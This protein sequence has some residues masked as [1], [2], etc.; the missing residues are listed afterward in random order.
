[1]I[2]NPVI[3]HHY[4]AIE[5]NIGAGKTTLCEMISK[6]YGCKLI[7]EQ[8]TDN[9]FLAS[10]YEQPE[11]YA[12]PVELFFMTERHK[13]M[14]EVFRDTD[15]F[16][17]FYLSDYF[18]LKTLLF[19]GKNL[20][21][22]EFRLFNR[23]FE[24]LNAPFPKPDLLV[25]LHRPIDVLMKNINKRGR[26]Y[27]TWIT[28]E[29][30][31]KVQDGY[32]DFFKSYNANESNREEMKLNFPVLIIHMQEIDFSNDASAYQKILELISMI[33]PP[34]VTEIIL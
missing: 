31:N 30:L 26:K 22:E 4:L 9:P 17:P 13:Q 11:R 20:N 25:Y 29:Y 24:V 27:E 1:M 2:S 14:Q 16:N 32:F 6:N 7:L 19:A 3:P 34:G 10:F 23:L 12:F 21:E 28:R 15:L 18:F 33:Y 5:G 8:F